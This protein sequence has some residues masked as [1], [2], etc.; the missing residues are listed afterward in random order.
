M[1]GQQQGGGGAALRERLL[2]GRPVTPRHAQASTPAF[3]M[4]IRAL[5]AKAGVSVDGGSPT[6]LQ[7]HDER[8]YERV[9]RFGSI[10]AGESYMDGWW[11]V[12]DLSGFFF[13]ILHA[14]LEGSVN[15]VGSLLYI[16]R[17]RLTNMQNRR[18]AFQV[19]EEHYDIGNDLYEHM[20]DKRMV[21]SC[22]YWKN[23]THLDEAQ[24]AK[25]DLVC[26][27][28][29]LKSGD[30]VLDIG[31]GWGSFAQF[32][33]CRYG[34]H[35]TGVT[36]SKEQ[37]QFAREQVKGL[38]V[39]IRLE[40]YRDTRGQFDHIVSLGMFEHVGPKN[41]GAYMGRVHA[42]LRDGGLFLLHTIGAHHSVWHTDPWIHTYIFPNGVLPSV[43][44]VG[45]AIDRL[46]VLED[47]HNFG[48]DYDKTLMAWYDNFDRAWP[49]L[50]HYGQ[51]FYRAWRYYLLTS[52][53]SFRARR[54]QVWQ[55]VLSPHGH[56]HGY[57]RPMI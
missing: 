22:G 37:V 26:R 50:L 49:S 31:C 7:V 5:L 6:D 42:L 8:V 30:R 40:D 38:P 55:L 39:E 27:K 3:K 23:A 47:W 29:G 35:V 15:D 56:Q 1:V 9:C 2:P 44:Q 16:L 20:L 41:Y 57:R 53:G 46:F 17:A 51:R 33:A 36:V 19:G 54:N 10:G 24:E 45:S 4:K 25:L 21:Y 43:A 34:A 14:N 32:A 48:A 12:D 28:L 18:R 13:K 11:D 52:A